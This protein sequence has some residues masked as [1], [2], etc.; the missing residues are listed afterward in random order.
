M[1]KNTKIIPVEAT[2]EQ[3]DAWTEAAKK[4]GLSRAQWVRY[5][6]NNYA[7][8]PQPELVK[9]GR[10]RKNVEPV[11]PEPV[12]GTPVD[13]QPDPVDAAV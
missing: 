7:G 12:A 4:E 13:V 10:P 3:V 5:A 6:C 2:V 9:R 11:A 8:L 1:E